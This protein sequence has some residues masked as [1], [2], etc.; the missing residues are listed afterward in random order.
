MADKSIV[1]TTLFI[2]VHNQLLL[3]SILLVFQVPFTTLL[4][5]AHHHMSETA[6]CMPPPTQAF[7]ALPAF[8]QPPD[9]QMETVTAG[10]REQQQE[11]DLPWAP[12]SRPHLCLKLPASGGSW[13]GPAS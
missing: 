11:Q 12:A 13:R 2:D 7:T 10:C 8:Q 6:H 3:P 9:L 5:A 1:S 4:Q